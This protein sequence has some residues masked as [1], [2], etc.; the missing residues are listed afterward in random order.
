MEWSDPN[1]TP[2]HR[3]IE[4]ARVLANAGRDE[5]AL[6]MLL[7]AVAAT[8]RKR[9]PL[10]TPSRRDSGTMGEREAFETFLT[11]EGG[12][13]ASLARIRSDTKAQICPFSNSSTSGSAARLRTRRPFQLTS[14]RSRRTFCSRLQTATARGRTSPRAFSRR[15]MS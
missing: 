2:V 8:A 6:L 4:D 14:N 13:S 10:G 5:G 7:V 3:R 12:G 1:L 11:E 9:F 15:S